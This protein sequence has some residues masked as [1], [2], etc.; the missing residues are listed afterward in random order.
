MEAAREGPCAGIVSGSESTVS[1]RGRTSTRERLVL[2][3]T[4]E[5]LEPLRGCSNEDYG[6]VVTPR[7][8]SKKIDEPLPLSLYLN[9]A[10]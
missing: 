2:A 10:I 3:Q 1:E 5:E 8:L 6:G 9:S 7:Y 4:K